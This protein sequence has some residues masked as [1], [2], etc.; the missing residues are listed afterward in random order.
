MSE[1]AD[2]QQVLVP[3]PLNPPVPGVRAVNRVHNRTNQKTLVNTHT[4]SGHNYTNWIDYV[5]DLYKELATINFP[6]S[7]ENARVTL[8]K[9]PPLYTCVR[10]LLGKNIPSP[11]DFL[12]ITAR[13]MGKIYEWHH[14]REL[15]QHML[16]CQVPFADINSRVNSAGVAELVNNVAA[17]RSYS[18]SYF[19]ANFIQNFHKLEVKLSV[20]VPEKKEKGML[21]GYKNVASP[22]EE[23]QFDMIVYWNKVS[24]NA[25]ELDKWDK[26]VIPV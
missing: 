16:L 19:I 8:S 1:E 2:P 10:G 23:W 21:Y 25:N 22:V 9:C 12:Q 26:S 5:D 14:D 6:I 13:I 18:K 3:S 4:P 11:S 20:T 24:I 17:L 15:P 7:D